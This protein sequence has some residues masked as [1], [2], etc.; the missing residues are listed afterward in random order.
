MGK[1]VSRFG[2]PDVLNVDDTERVQSTGDYLIHY[3]PYSIYILVDAYMS[4]EYDYEKIWEDFDH[5][6]DRMY[7]PAVIVLGDAI[8]KEE[9]YRHGI[10]HNIFGPAIIEYRD[11]KLYQQEW[12]RMGKLHRL[13]G[14]A[15]IVIKG[16]RDFYKIERW[17]K[18]G[19]LHNAHGASII[20][21]YVNGIIKQKEWYRYGLLRNGNAPGSVW[22]GAKGRKTR[23]YWYRHGA[24]YKTIKYQ[25]DNKE[26]YMIISWYENHLLSR[27]YGPA[28]VIY[29]PNK[30]IKREEWYQKSKLH[31][32]TGPAVIEYYP[33]G[34]RKL[35]IWFNK[36][37]S[38]VPSP[39]Q[40]YDMAEDSFIDDFDVNGIY[41]HEKDPDADY[42]EDPNAKF[43]EYTTD[44]L[45]L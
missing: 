21:Y 36:G 13:S 11:R 26:E 17:Y 42:I 30:I 15:V 40:Y 27:D 31:R 45:L 22:Y 34:N 29:F 9:W 6:P 38:F 5:K 35:Q 43:V 41:Y 28:R 2:F 7:G 16:S 25:P 8:I 37:Q 4:I 33:D 3:M 14:P 24:L 19:Q 44:V 18:D 10:L 20:I 23:E 1:A 32:T 39:Q 12:Y